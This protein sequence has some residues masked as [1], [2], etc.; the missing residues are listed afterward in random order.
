MAAGD[1]YLQ[2]DQSIGFSNVTSKG[3]YLQ[4]DEN[5]IVNPLASVGMITFTGTSVIRKRITTY[6]GTLVG[7]A[8][9]RFRARTTFIT[10]I[11]PPQPP[12]GDWIVPYRTR[13]FIWPYPAL[14]ERGRPR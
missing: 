3:A 7:M 11:I 9:I 2:A 4:S 6:E 13:R 10:K 5:V 1:A 8:G 12:P 14:D